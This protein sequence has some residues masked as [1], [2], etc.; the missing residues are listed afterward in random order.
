MGVRLSV[1]DLIPVRTGQTTAQAV[2]ATVRLARLADRLGLHRYWVAEHHN[3]RDVASTAPP[4]LV[5]LLGAAT[6]RIRVGSGGV[7]LL[8]HQPIVVAEQFA[9]LDAALGGRVDLGIGRAPGTDPVTTYVLRPGQSAHEQESAYPE[10]VEELVELLAGEF[11]V[12]LADGRRVP[13]AATPAP[14]GPGPHLWLLGSSRYSARLAG[15]LGIDYV[16]ASHFTGRGTAEALAEYRRERGAGAPVITTANVVVADT[17]AEARELAL[18]ALIGMA[19]RH[20]V[21]RVGPRLTV[22]EAARMTLTAEQRAL[23]D[24]MAAAW[25]IGT[26]DEVADR[27]TTFAARHG[28]GEVIVQP[29]AGAHEGEPLD[30]APQ[31]ERTLRLLVERLPQDG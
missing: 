10:R 26:S 1:L 11:S 22:E 8:N 7:M 17:A 13:V 23:V 5:A 14:A 19:Q 31:R 24:R 4:V 9:L 18:P 15:R 21:G 29:V 27:L 28:V 25:T 12:E 2:A 6:E 3:M 16:F 20:L 30:A